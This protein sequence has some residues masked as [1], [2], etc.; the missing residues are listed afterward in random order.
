MEV[1]AKGTV[2]AGEPGSDNQSCTFPEICVLPSGRWLCTIRATKIKKSLVDNH[3]LVTFSDDEG[4]TWSEP[5]AP[6]D[7]PEVDGKAG[8]FRTS[9]PTILPDG[10][11]ICA[12]C[13]V[14]ISDPS[15]PFFNEETKGILNS[16]PFFSY[17]DD[18]G[19]SWSKPE[20]MNTP[21]FDIPFTL[22]GGVIV[23]PDGTLA[24]QV[25][26]YKHYNDTVSPWRH[27]SV[28]IY[29]Y[30][31][32]RT[33]GDYV[34]T[35]GDPENRIYYWDQ[36]PG[37]MT[38]GRILN[39][40]WTYDTKE[41]KFRN[42]HGRESMDS[43]KN[44]SDMWDTGVQTQPAQPLQM[45]NGKVLMAYV[46][47]TDVPIIKLRASDDMG[48]TWPKESEIVLHKGSTLQNVV[49]K[50]MTDTWMEIADYS[51]GLPATE[52]MSSGDILVVYYAGEQID[53]TKI[54][55][56]RVRGSK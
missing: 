16:M 27:R 39:V 45:P 34:Y 24:C 25:E 23:L 7:P 8:V 50:T 41:A 26:T 42:I 38:D 29:S 19:Q 18:N 22:T 53:Q 36:R 17:S 37:V 20:L 4:K 56:A 3:Q 13:W 31:S 1:V 6:F 12:M 2:F 9:A 40:Y 46:D 43:G 33:W 32:G 55:W 14:D 5:R 35:S 21:P 47:R 52:R 15:L 48:R 30:N 28:L 44:W 11:V 10:R 49:K 51:I 54:Y